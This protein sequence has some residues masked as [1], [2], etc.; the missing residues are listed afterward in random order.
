[1]LY[2]PL[3]RHRV[4]RPLSRLK[5]TN[6][7]ALSS[8]Q[9]GG[10]SQP[11]SQFEVALEPSPDL[12]KGAYDTSVPDMPARGAVLG[13]VWDGRKGWMRRC[14]VHARSSR[15]AHPEP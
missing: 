8:T 14:C 15:G 4:P 5:S 10:T 11:D 1:M 7:F 3:Q 9:Q 2:L 13:A 12:W 6:L